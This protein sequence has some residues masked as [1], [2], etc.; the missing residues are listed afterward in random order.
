MSDQQAMKTM[1]PAMCPH[2]SKEFIVAFTTFMP[3]VSWVLKEQ[4]LKDAKEKVK[5]KVMEATSIND[6]EKVRLMAW[7]DRKETVFGPE[8]IEVLLSQIMP[9]EKN[10]MAVEGQIEEDKEVKD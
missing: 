6:E 9:E 4:D 3:S 1:T 10:V 7:L 8:E 2:C 5:T